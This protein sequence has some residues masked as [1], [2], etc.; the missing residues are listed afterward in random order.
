MKNCR[1]GM[2]YAMQRIGIVLIGCLAGGHAAAA[3]SDI[4][5]NGWFTWRVTATADAPNWCCYEWNGGISTTRSCD[6][7]T[8]QGNFGA[9]SDYA[10]NVDQMQI[11]ALLDAGVLIKLRTVSAQCPVTSR[12][13]ISDLGTVDVIQS[14][15]WLEKII[16]PHSELSSQALASI[17]IHDGDESRD[18][19]IDV[20]RHDSDPENR[21]DALFWMA[22]VR[23][24]ETGGEIKKLM[25]ND[26]SADFREHAAFALSQS[27]V[28]DRED[29]LAK[30]GREDK[31]GDVRAKA[32]FWLAQTG[33]VASDEEIQKAIRREQDQD[34]RDEVIFALSQLPVD[35]AFQALIQVIEDRTLRNED[36]KQ[37]IFWLAQSDSDRALEYL[38][39]L[40]G[41]R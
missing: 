13:A 28:G 40:I 41:G 12:S 16:S 10:D 25:F 6:L 18:V 36:R 23:S 24:L 26:E 17:A 30:L 14:V 33:S 2:Q 19:L 15:K 5:G 11:Y 1:F 9:H 29:A 38:G 7:D 32:W 22:Q 27:T 21:E 35:R 31:V 39:R 4:D 8:R 37:A 20:A 3:L 34:V